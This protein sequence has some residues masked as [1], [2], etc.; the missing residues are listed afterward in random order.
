VGAQSAQSSRETLAYGSK[1]PFFIAPVNLFK[2][3]GGFRSHLKYRIELA[4]DVM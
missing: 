3:H 4:L 2:N 1:F